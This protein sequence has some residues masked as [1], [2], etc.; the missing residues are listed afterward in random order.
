MQDT[1]QF[2]KSANPIKR[3]NFLKTALAAAAAPT[4]IPSSA[5][6]LAGNT[7]PSERITMGLIGCGGHGCGWNL[8]RMFEN[9]DQQVVAV[10]DVDSQ[11]MENARQKVNG[12]YSKKLGRDYKCDTYGDFRDLINRKDIDAVDVVTPD[13]WHVIPALMAVKAGKHVICEK[14][15]SITVSEGRVLADASKK[16]G[17]VFQTASENRSI[18]SYIHMCELVHGGYIG[19]LQHI[20]VLLPKGNKPRGN[21]NFTVQAPPEQLNYDMWQGQAPVAPYCPARVHNTFRWNQAYSGGVLCDWGA[22]M[23]DLA[24]WASGNQHSGPVEVHG[25]GDFPPKDA[26]WNTPPTF[27]L[28]Y[29]YKD[30]LTM[31]VWAEAPA[32]KFEGSEGWIMFRGWRAPLRASNPKILDE[33]IPAEKQ[34]HRPK[35]IVKRDGPGIPGGEHC[36]FTDAIKSG[37]QAYAPAEIGHRTISVAH[38]GNIAMLTGRKLKW[39]PDKEQFPGDAEANAMLSRKQREPWSIKNVDSWINV[40]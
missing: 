20:K 34:L 4:V 21:D 33:K 1:H 18:D 29:R 2:S 3:R 28:H 25:K 31:H 12:H 9:N 30:G 17:K 11:H 7:T 10:C 23:I 24:Q 27:D 8:P 35:L 6:G 22:H 32:I 40:G 16:S 19:Q 37:K 14:P 13:H 39:D 26:V 5:F 38:I 36:D 15:L